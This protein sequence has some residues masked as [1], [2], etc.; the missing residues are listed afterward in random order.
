MVDQSPSFSDLNLGAAVP[1]S[2]DTVKT[3]AMIAGK[4]VE[5]VGRRF[6]EEDDEDILRESSS[7]FVL[8]PIKYHEVSA[9]H[10]AECKLT[11]R[12]GRRIKLPKLGE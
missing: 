3:K 7:R 1:E 9:V 6:P 11:I 2:M 12:F 8:F 5:P 10:F 4:E